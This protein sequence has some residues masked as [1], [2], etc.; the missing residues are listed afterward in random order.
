MLSEQLPSILLIGCG[1]MGG[2]LW[3]GW[4][5][6]DIAPSVI[7]DRHFAHVPDPHRICRNATEIPSDFKPEY[8]VL[9]VKPAKMEETLQAITPWLGEAV[10]ISVMAGRNINDMWRASPK[11]G[12]RNPIIRS[13]PNTPSEIG[14][15]VTGAFGLGLSKAQHEVS[16]KILGAVGEVV[17]VDKEDE[18]EILSPLSGSGPAYVFLFAE[19][20]E[21]E[22]IA[23]GLRPELARIVARRTVSGAG[24]LLEETGE[25]SATLRRNVT[26]PNGVTQA[27]LNVF[28]RDEQGMKQLVSEAIA[29]GIQRTKELSRSS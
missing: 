13:I 9:A 19:L 1:H 10:I 24:A 4:L 6:H 25:D 8:I 23:R 16:D 3:R 12:A 7:V 22:A 5:R 17:W 20:L 2:A 18:I 14:K 11:T 26:S 28:M 29:A 15:G 21:Q 27:A